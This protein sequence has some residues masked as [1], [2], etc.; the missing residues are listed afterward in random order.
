M[1][2]S[3][4]MEPLPKPECQSLLRAG[5]VGILAL[6]GDRAPV[7]RPVNYAV[8]EGRIVIRTGQG[9]IFEAARR[10]EPASFV[11]SEIDRFEHEGWSVV[12]TG[13]LE[14]CSSADEL[15]ELPLR[16]WARAVKDRFVALSMDEISGRRIA[17][18]GVEA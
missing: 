1:S 16:P 12:V 13:R 4:G 2:S 5:G 6:P 14:E 17:Q 18:G 3:D 10:A 7:L 8:Q 15:V 11:I 9:Q